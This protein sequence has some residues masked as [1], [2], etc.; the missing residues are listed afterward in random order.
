[1]TPRHESAEIQ[2]Q[3]YVYVSRLAESGA[4]PDEI[5]QKLIEKGVASLRAWRTSIILADHR[6]LEESMVKKVSSFSLLA[7]P[8][9]RPS[10]NQRTRCLEVPW[11]NF[12]GCTKPPARR[13]KRSSP[14]ALAD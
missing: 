6:S 8:V 14:M 2:G 11:V 4:T 3:V 7:S 5:R 10:L 13:C 9:F 1:M 12:S